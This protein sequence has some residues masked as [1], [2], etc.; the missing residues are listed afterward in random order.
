MNFDDAYQP[1]PSLD[2]A[3]DDAGVLRFR[4]DKPKKRN[5][6][7]DDMVAAMI[8]A[9]D[10]AGRDERVRAIL[11]TGAG[12]HF[13]SGF[14]I[15]GRNAANTPK[16]RAGA[17]QRRLPS[18]NHRLIPLLCTVQVP[19]VCAVQG[20]TAGVG[21]HV[22]AA[23]DFT[24]AA[25]DAKL[26]EPFSQRGFTP[27]SGGTWLLP[28][29]VG[30]ARARELL[31]LG[32]SLSGTEA[33]AWGLVH[34]AV[35]GDQLVAETEALVAQLATGP[36]V[37]LGLTKLLLHTGASA[38]L[39]DHLRDEAMAMEISSRSEDFREGLEAF[40]GKRDPDFKGR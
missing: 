24:L 14:D 25:D 30:T 40:V 9:V 36:T 7:D 16:Q 4:F 12:D 33:E 26:W 11:V 3:L 32:R 35:P 38:S 17:I 8:G 5:A 37:T 31:L 10:A 18:E 20:W 27:D 15:V 13:C 23:A 6:L 2:V 1:V 19:V 39:P 22:A 28:R 21:L 34:R 29:L